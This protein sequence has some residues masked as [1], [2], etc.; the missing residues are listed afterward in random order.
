M[1]FEL[2]ETVAHFKI[3]IKNTKLYSQAFPLL[4]GQ[5]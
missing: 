3:L 4:F 2:K 5:L 1:K